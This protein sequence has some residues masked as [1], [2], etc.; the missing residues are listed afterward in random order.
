MAEEGNNVQEPTATPVEPTETP[1]EPQQPARLDHEGLPDELKGMSVQDFSRVWDLTR[2]ALSAQ[3]MAQQ[4]MQQ[5]QQQQQPQEPSAPADDR[6][7]AERLADPESA[8]DALH[9]WANRTYGGVFESMAR[10]SHDSTYA[11]LRQEVSDFA[12]KYEQRTKEVIS[13]L[14]VPPTQVTPEVIRS[15]YYIARGQIAEEESKRAKPAPT[16]ITTEA[17][18]PR[19]P[20][21]P[22]RQ[23]TPEQREIAARLRMS[24]DKYVEWLDKQPGYQ[25][26]DIPMEPKYEHGKPKAD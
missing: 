24:E 14:K 3:Q 16:T 9:E 23:L 1:P 2:Q 19:P 15:A 10:S 25:I 26:V 18:T 21:S 7:L 13:N 8:E 17:P 4:Q 20:E 5:Q 12:D 22:K 11:S 6:P